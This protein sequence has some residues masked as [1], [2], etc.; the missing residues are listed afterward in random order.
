MYFKIV[1]TLLILIN[2]FNM[3]VDRYGYSGERTIIYVC[4]GI[5]LLLT[6]CCW[7]FQKTTYPK[8]FKWLAIFAFIIILYFFLQFT[9]LNNEYFQLNQYVRLLMSVVFFYFFYLYR[10]SKKFEIYFKIFIIT[11][12]LQCGIKII[13]GHWFVNSNDI[14]SLTGGDTV[15]MGLSMVVPL[16]FMFFKEKWAFVLFML[17]F[18]FV[19]LSLRRTSILAMVISLPFIWSSIKR[20]INFKTLFVLLPIIVFGII[21]AWKYVG[22]QLVVRFAEL[23]EGDNGNDNSFGSGRTVYWAQIL[24]GYINSGNYLFGNGMGSVFEFFSKENMYVKLPHAHNDVLELLYTFGFIGAIVWC[25]F[26]WDSL[27][28]TINQ[29]KSKERQL[30]FCCIAIYIFVGFSSGIILRAEFFPWVIAF[31]ILLKS[32]KTRIKY[33]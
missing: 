17:S 7:F 26:I 23:F 4:N 27:K 18:F 19:C 28:D 1:M 25:M 21:A 3:I 10:P 11:Y 15:S 31:A 22:P 2:L 32:I 14:D 5:I 8:Y 6:M 33:E 13:T 9:I 29:K 20:Y 12:I 30:L 16:I 24:K